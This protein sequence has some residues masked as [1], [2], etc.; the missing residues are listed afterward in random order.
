V[1][2]VL[3]PIDWGRARVIVEYGPGVGTFTAEILKRMNR[4]AHLIAIETNRDFVRFLRKSI[5]DPRLH[6]EHDSAADVGLV[7]R[8]LG[9]PLANYVIS[10]IPLG[11]M[12]EPICADIVGKSCAVLE[13]GGEFLV[14]QFTSRALPVLRRTFRHVRRSVERRNLPPALLF[15]CA[16]DA[17]VT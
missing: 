10:G 4:D 9:M 14:Y 2:Q 12:P 1:N 15:V 16:N 8:R 7:L 17:A 5:Q 13:P 11:S 3:E 6:L